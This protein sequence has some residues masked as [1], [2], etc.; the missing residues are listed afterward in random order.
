[1]IQL[2]PYFTLEEAIQSD[3][4][5]RLNIDN[6]PDAGTIIIM[7]TAALG[8]ERVRA[9]LN[10]PV[11]VNSWYRCPHLN[12]VVG[13][14]NTSQHLKGEAIDFRSL[15]S[16][17]EICRKLIENVDTINYDQLILEHTWVHISFAILTG[18][19]RHQVLSLLANK[20][21]AQGLT[22]INGI[23]Y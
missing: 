19:P 16:P 22:D 20:K 10:A 8:M 23:M 12:T 11:N 9:V 2:S 14:F 5:L 21:Y 4:A 18:K 17:L 6:T 13:S 7:K 1:M 15:L 3:T